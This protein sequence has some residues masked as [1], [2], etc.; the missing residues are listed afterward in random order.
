MT[1]PGGRGRFA[2]RSARPAIDATVLIVDDFE[3]I[4]RMLRL[5]LELADGIE[6]VGEAEDG[7]AALA[8]IGERTPDVVILDNHMPVMTG[9][10]MLAHLRGDGRCRGG[11]RH[12]DVH[13]RPDGR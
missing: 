3:P 11:H 10:E 13:Q 8:L 1:A 6:V 9:V 5:S 12:C 4:R 7:S 2:D